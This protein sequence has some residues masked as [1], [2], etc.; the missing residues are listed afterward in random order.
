MKKIDHL[1][2]TH[3]HIDHFRRRGGHLRGVLMPTGQVDDKA[4]PETDP[5]IPPSKTRWPIA[6]QPLSRFSRGR[7]AARFTPET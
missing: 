6:I 1:V 3:F 5:D 4:I 7:R 2:T